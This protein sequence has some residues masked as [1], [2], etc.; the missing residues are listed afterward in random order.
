MQTFKPFNENSFAPDKFPGSS[1][2]QRGPLLLSTGIS[3]LDRNLGGGLP[4]GSVTYFT[5]DPRSMSEVFLYQFTQS[6]RTFYFTTGRRSKH[7]LG[8]IAGMGFDTSSINFI[9]VYNEYYFTASGERSQNLGNEIMDSKIVEY[10]EFNLRNIATEYA[11]EE[12]TLIID[13]FSFFLNL[14]VNSGLIRQLTNTIYEISKDVKCLVFL[15]AHKGSIAERTNNEL[16]ALVDVIFD[17]SMENA[18][19][20]LVSKLAIPKIRD[21]VPASEVIKFKIGDGVQIDTSR[22]IA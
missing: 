13:S 11:D 20:K 4:I 2:Q 17:S 21:K 7:V 6:R 3:V 9:D 15:Y 10:M 16:S 12:I 8:N 19:D 18:S 5:A 22:D 14:N 1:N